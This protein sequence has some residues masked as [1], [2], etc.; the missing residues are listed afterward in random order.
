VTDDP[1]PLVKALAATDP[2]DLIQAVLDRLDAL[3]LQHDALRLLTLDSLKDTTSCRCRSCCEASGALLSNLALVERDQ[4]RLEF[5]SELV[6]GISA[7]DT[8]DVAA[9]Q[10]AVKTNAR[11]EAVNT[12]ERALHSDGEVV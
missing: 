5:A 10:Q 2:G 7:Y 3:A 8:P 11:C 1:S 9:L 12:L 6:D 4:Q